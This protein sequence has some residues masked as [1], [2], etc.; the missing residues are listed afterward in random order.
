MLKQE[1]ILLVIYANKQ[2]NLTSKIRLIDLNRGDKARV[3]KIGRDDGV[4]V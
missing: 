3:L 2:D 4:A 1:T